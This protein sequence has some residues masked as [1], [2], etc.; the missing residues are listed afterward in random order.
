MNYIKQI[1]GFT[2]GVILT[3]LLVYFFR[4]F[5][6]N[7]DQVSTDYYV[8][9]NQISKMNKMVVI[10]QDFSNLQ[11][12]KITNLLFG[13]KGLPSSEKEIVIFTKAKAQVTYDLK[14]MKIEVDSAD[15][16]LIIKEIPNAD[17]KIFTDAEITSLDDSFFDRFS[18]EDFKRITTNAKKNAEK[19]VDQTKLRN[20][21]RKQLLQNLNDIFV[22]AKALKYE[23]VDD[24]NTFDLSKL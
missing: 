11:K 14:K 8:L 2:I 21:G 18:E 5:G 20:E 16:K 1:I 10:E 24:T 12:T 19:T 23:V 9:T 15:K 6:K 4:N 22:L 17:I 3:L 7:D 13:I